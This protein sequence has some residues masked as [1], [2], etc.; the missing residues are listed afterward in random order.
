MV[1]IVRQSVKYKGSSLQAGKEAWFA[2]EETIE[3]KNSKGNAKE[4][5]EQQEQHEEHEEQEK[6]VKR[7]SKTNQTQILKCDFNSIPTPQTP[8]AK[9]LNRFESDLR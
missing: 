1:G 5:E 3:T 4:E 9:P 7:E 6:K 2:I 8:N